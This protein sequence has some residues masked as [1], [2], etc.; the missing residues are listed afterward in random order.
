MRETLRPALI[1][2]ALL[3]TGCGFTPMYANPHTVAGLAG[4][5]VVEPHG[6]FGHLLHEDLD[7]A[8]GRDKS[9]QPA[10]RLELVVDQTRGA[11]GLTREDVSRYYDVGVTVRYVLRATADGKTL[12]S[13]EISTQ[14]S[15]D[16]SGQAYADIMA[17]QDAQARAASDAARRIQ[18]KLASYMARQAASR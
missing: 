2:A 5:E 15:Y 9:A 4:I 13:G 8:L 11:R 14:V 12:D 6:R 7:D 18:L 1:G 3:L 10:Y 17:A 16:D